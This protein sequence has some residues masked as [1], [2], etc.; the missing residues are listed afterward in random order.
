VGNLEVLDLSEPE[1]DH[2]LDLEE[3]P[4]APNAPPGPN[5]G[6]PNPGGPKPGGPNPGGPNPGG[7]KPG[8]P[9]NLPR[10]WPNTD[11]DDV[12]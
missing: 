1:E 10:W 12:H 5:P 8:P 3:P 7:P 4:K 6:G 2:S 11:D 9:P